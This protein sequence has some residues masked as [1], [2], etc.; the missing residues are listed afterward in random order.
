M[1]DHRGFTENYDEEIY[2]VHQMSCVNFCDVHLDIYSANETFAVHS[3][4]PFR[5]GTNKACVLPGI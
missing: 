3:R 4:I 2:Y 5:P 1:P